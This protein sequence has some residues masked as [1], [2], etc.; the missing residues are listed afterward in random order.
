MHV[1]ISSALIFQ[2]IMLFV[3]L[4]FLVTDCSALFLRLLLILEG[5]LRFQKSYPTHPSVFL[6]RIPTNTVALDCLKEQL[7]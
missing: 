2:L 5:T 3:V 6:P 1:N 4:Y 7:A